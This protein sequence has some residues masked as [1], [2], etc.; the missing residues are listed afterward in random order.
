MFD[1]YDQTA[2]IGLSEQINAYADQGTLKE[3][4]DDMPSLRMSVI[5]DIYK[6]LNTRKAPAAVIKRFEASV[7]KFLN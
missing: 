5:R 7:N 2:V 6:S 1:Q 4:V 3:F